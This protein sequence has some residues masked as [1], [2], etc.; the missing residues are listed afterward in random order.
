MISR[1]GGQRLNIVAI[2]GNVSIAINGIGATACSAEL[3]RAPHCGLSVVLRRSFLTFTR[4]FRCHQMNS[5]RDHNYI[6]RTWSKRVAAS[7][8]LTRLA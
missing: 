6:A 3:K 4:P 8:L 5:G 2:P 1:S 7:F